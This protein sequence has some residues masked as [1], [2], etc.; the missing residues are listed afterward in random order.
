MRNYC[1]VIFTWL[2]VIAATVQAQHPA[3]TT[4][5]P[6]QYEKGLELFGYN[7]WAGARASFQQFLDNK[8]V[9][10]ND[11]RRA[12]AS[13]Y[14]AI[15]ALR[16]GN[17]DAEVL[18]ENFVNQY[19]QHPKA[20]LAYYEL[21][22]H[23]YQKNNLSKALTYLELSDKSK[24]TLAQQEELDFTI[25]Y[26]YF[27][28]KQFEEALNRFNQLKRTENRFSYAASYYA[29]YI[30]YTRG[31]YDQA[32]YDLERAQ[33][34]EAYAKV[35]PPL[36]ANIY[37]RQKQY[38]RL[39]T[40]VEAN[41]D[42]VSNG[43]ELDLLAAEAYYR[44]N[45]YAKAYDLF[46][47]YANRNKLSQ[48][49]QY[50][51]AFAALKT[52]NNEVAI[53]NFKPIA[54]SKD[55]LAQYAA[56][57]L[58]TLYNKEGNGTY[59]LAAFNKAA[60]LTVDKN[61]QQESSFL[62]GKLQYDNEQYEQAA[63]HFKT[64]KK[65]YPN[66]RFTAEV[67]DL[68]SNALINTRNY[69]QAITYLEQIELNT[70]RLEAAYQQVTYLRGTEE[71]ND[72]N[73]YNA[74]KLWEKSL[75]HPVDRTIAGQAHFWRGEAYSIGKK[76]N[77]AIN[78]YAGV[79]RTL[80]PDADYH[81]R[82]RYGIGYAYYNTAQ[83]DKALTHFKEYVNRTGNTDPYYKDALLRLADSYYANK[84]YSEAVSNY[85][86]AIDAG[87]KEADY[88]YLQLGLVNGLQDNYTEA[89]KNW[90]YIL[91]N[92]P[93]STYAD[94]AQYNLAQIEFEQG[95]YQAAIPL[96]N[97]V[98]NVYS[99]SAFVPY[100]YRSKAL[101]LYNLGQY[102][103]ARK[104][105]IDGLERYASH[106]S[107]YS[108]LLGLQDVLSQLNRSEEF[109]R[110]LSLYKRDNTS[111]ESLEEVEY[112]AAK[113][114]YFAQKYKQA[115]EKLQQ[116]MAEYPKSSRQEEARFYL[117]E[118]YYYNKEVQSA[119]MQ[120]Q[121][122]AKSPSPNIK[123]RSLLRLA[124]I[125]REQQDWSKAISYYR[126]LVSVAQNRREQSDGYQGLMEAYHQKGMADSTLYFA[127]QL[128]IL[129]GDAGILSGRANLIKGNTYLNR[130]DLSAA[131]QAFNK[132]VQAA[133]DQSAAEAFYK[134]AYIQYLEKQYEESINSLYEF[135]SRYGS[136]TYW[137]GKAF[138]LIAENNLKMGE[139][140]QAKETLKSIIANSTE[141]SIVEEAKQRLKDVEQASAAEKAKA[142]EVDSL[143]NNR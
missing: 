126:S 46:G 70:V 93:K 9:D 43:S 101:A 84:I 99:N 16:L 28:K 13:Y 10:K 44:K 114:L 86:K 15:S 125:N 121:S 72:G 102:E 26:I 58:G 87:A 139:E 21:G 2:M 32:A 38:D 85:R 106:S 14:L 117:A 75:K 143:E 1:L 113:N 59:A 77:D 107:G 100:A 55:S 130:E 94:D 111:G 103:E 109:D 50:R 133:S 95:N 19:S 131:R 64:F 7:Q 53:T 27:G 48:Q 76:W 124:T 78:S 97:K 39:I 31:E 20:S 79:F 135:N 23:F 115:I 98:I 83:Y 30:Y 8:S 49:A 37:Y 108:M 67:N 141:A 63:N 128:L 132:T 57:Y 24:L 110:Y 41:R 45:Q 69:D 127:D 4:A 22:T 17:N 138:L 80:P 3:I 105:Y 137:L 52:E 91:S 74:V 81:L 6:R 89:K 73:F 47:T 34:N 5:V 71:F 25:A 65:N 29:G 129:E 40:Y 60:D 104:T 56:Y 36:M 112:S 90:Q 119:L 140:F 123:N 88:V 12:E 18:A 136:Y 92:Y 11:L 33:K 61:I 96:F 82:T 54:D 116:F 62:V 142:V 118:S 134:L 42:Q 68:L 122:L 35:V 51:Y 120:Y 66:S